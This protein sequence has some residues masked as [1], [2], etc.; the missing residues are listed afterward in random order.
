MKNYIFLMPLLLLSL[1]L[2]AV[3]LGDRKS[4]V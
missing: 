1:G 2:L 3:V 4:V